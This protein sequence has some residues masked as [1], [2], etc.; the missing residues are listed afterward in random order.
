MKMVNQSTPL[1]STYTA[2]SCKQNNTVLVCKYIRVATKRPSKVGGKKFQATIS[3][4][5]PCILPE[6]LNIYLMPPYAE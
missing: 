1:S 4:G 2:F 6:V 5:L 3:Q